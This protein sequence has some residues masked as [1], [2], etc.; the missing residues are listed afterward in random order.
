MVKSLLNALN[1]SK[2]MVEL[3]LFFKCNLEKV[4]NLRVVFLKIIIKKNI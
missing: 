4:K 3:N 2:K 1:K